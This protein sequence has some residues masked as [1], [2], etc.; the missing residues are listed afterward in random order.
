MKKVL[1][2]GL[3]LTFVISIAIVAIAAEEMFSLKGPIVS[4]DAKA[5]TVT[6]NSV[7]G[8]TTAADNRWKGNVTFAIN[9]MTKISMDKEKKTFN[10]LKA[11]QNVK[12]KFHE[13]NGKSSAVE[14]MIM[15]G[16]KASGY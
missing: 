2:I 10:D 1:A 4:V 14:I 5:K 3:A 11:G 8:V 7:E 13:K 12:V 15:S 6:V 9:D 16:K